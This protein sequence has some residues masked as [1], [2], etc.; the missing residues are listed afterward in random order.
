LIGTR[1]ALFIATSDLRRRTWKLAG[2]HFSG[3]EVNH[4]IQDPRTGRLCA[5]LNST[6][7]GND[8]QT[9]DDG[10]KTRHS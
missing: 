5:A 3:W 1:K 6:W 7:L 10:G 2:P 9:S 4:A 8:L